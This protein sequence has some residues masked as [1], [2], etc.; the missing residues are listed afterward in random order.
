WKLPLT[1]LPKLSTADRVNLLADSW[2]LVQA[3]RAPLSLYLDLVE[4]LPT[5]DELAER[6]QIMLVFDF[7][8]RLL[9]GQPQRELFQKYARSVLQPSFEKVGWE[10]KRG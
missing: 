4:K 3:N 9:I 8:D 10:P 7:I 5:N 1:E 6:E 2:A